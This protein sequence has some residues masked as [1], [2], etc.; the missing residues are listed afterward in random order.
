MV[1]LGLW[2][3][4]VVEVMAWREGDSPKRSKFGM[5]RRWC[6]GGEK[7]SVGGESGVVGL[8]GYVCGGLGVI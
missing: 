6:G 1:C 4:G 3:R 8:G 5:V 7:V 2:V